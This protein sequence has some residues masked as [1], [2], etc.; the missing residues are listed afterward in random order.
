MARTPRT[1]NTIA[2]LPAR[3]E[4]PVAGSTSLKGSLVVDSPATVMLST[5][6][7]ND[8]PRSTTMSYVPGVLGAVNSTSATPLYTEALG[9]PKP[10]TNVL[11][12][13]TVCFNPWNVTVTVSEFLH[14]AFSLNFLPGWTTAGSVTLPSGTDTSV[15]DGTVVVVVVV[16]GVV[17]VVLVRVVEA[18]P[19]T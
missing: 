3:F 17:V 1:K 13:V 8:V 5:Y 9:R 14:L 12:H 4:P 2:T 18:R 11:S 15:N 10:L 19:P 6:R 7:S 16:V